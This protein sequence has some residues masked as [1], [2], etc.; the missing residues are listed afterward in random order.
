[1]K[2]RLT[3][4]EPNLLSQWKEMDLYQKILQKREGAPLWVLHDG[5]PYANGR[6]HLGTA[7]NKILKDIIIKAKTLEGFLSPYVPGWDCHGLPIENK[8]DKDLGPKKKDLTQS[9]VRQRCREYA[10]KYLNIQR[11]EFIRL[12]VLGD[13]SNPYL[14]MNYEYEAITARELGNIALAGRLSRSVK[15][16]LWCGSCRTALAEAEVEYGNH[17]SPTIFVEFQLKSPPE[18]ISPKLQGARV[19]FVIWTTTPWTIPANMGIAYSPKISYAAYE[20]KDP[21]L[22]TR[23]L[24][25]AQDLALKLLEQFGFSEYTE[26][27]VIDNA[28]LF[29]LI[30]EHPLYP[31]D[32][33]LVPALYVTL[34]QGTG[35]VHTAPGHGRE[36]YETGKAYDL[37]IFSPLDD[38]ARFTEEV[39]E[40]AGERVMETNFKIIDWLKEKNA[41]LA[42]S[43]LTHQYPHC[44]RCKNPVVFRATP[45]WFISMETLDLRRKSLQ[46]IDTVKWIPARGRERIYGMIENRPDW[47]V[48][49]QRAW[50]VPITIFF[51]EDCGEWFYTKEIQERLFQLFREH[52]ADIW[53]EKEAKDLLPPGQKCP[54]CGGQNFRKEKDILDVWF[55]SGSSFAAVMEARKDLPDIAQMYLEGSDQHR[56][57]FHSSL[58]ISEA[59]RGHPPYREVLTH[60]FIV[61]GTGKKMSK[62]LGNTV[63]PAEIIKKYGADI[64]RLWVASENYQDDIRVS[65]EIL[66]MLVKAYFN[67]RNTCRFL[68]GNLFDF[69]V[70]TDLFAPKDIQGPIEKFVLFRLGELISSVIEAYREYAFYEVYHKINNFMG[71]MSSFYLDILKD[72]LYTFKNTA[73]PRREAQ[74]VMFRLLKDVTILMAPILSFTAEEIWGHLV[75]TT[76]LPE[77]VFL[78]DFPDPKSYLELGDTV[79]DL[80]ILLVV[81][82][83]VNKALEE[84]RKLKTIG[85]S[86]DA[87]LTISCGSDTYALLTKYQK[88]LPELFIVSLVTLTL[89]DTLE[90]SLVL[91]VVTFYDVPKCPRCWNRHPSVPADLTDVCPKCKLALA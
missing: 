67:F 55:D 27:A 53:Y 54:H 3:E 17:E 61:D 11:D 63:E 5:P 24:V 87:S 90:A 31:R 57:W 60:G 32:S 12:G 14:T 8:V 10:E 9:Q 19:S 68:L 26:V 28:N 86:L 78:A 7:L 16:V 77:S 65:Q 62:S 88:I 56:G 33:K 2:G 64:L 34:E 47:C 58:L 75:K 35:L 40:L 72:R 37:P 29:G 70:A 51:C 4:L 81:R 79:Q 15:P 22:G 20:V 13:W 59:N 82:A 74:S 46:S 89:D 84:A 41:L 42:T 76:D 39:P 1:M 80:E 83:R 21:K 48:S 49:R 18:K 91:P 71:L 6:I 43:K 25:L 45:Q 73:P 30:C 38:L 23:V 52:G 66:D 44:W 69:N 85:S 36:D 50:G